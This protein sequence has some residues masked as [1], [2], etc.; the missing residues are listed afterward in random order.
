MTLTPNNNGEN[1]LSH[2]TLISIS[3]QFY[4]YKCKVVSLDFIHFNTK[5]MC[6]PMALLDI[7]TMP[8]INSINSGI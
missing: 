1:Y 5:Y 8:D 6:I 7:I 4:Q 3:H 2:P